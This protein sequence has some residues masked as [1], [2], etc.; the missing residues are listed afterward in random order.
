MLLHRDWGVDEIAVGLGIPEAQVRES[1]TRL[2]DLALLR[3][4][5]EAPKQVRRVSPEV[6]LQL[7]LE[8]R[9]AELLERQ[10]RLAASRAAV[11]ELLADYTAAGSGGV[12]EA[13]ERLDGIDAIQSR[14][15]ELAQRATSVCHSFMPGGA[16]SPQSLAASK[17]LDEQMLRCG[18]EVLTVYLTSMRND[19]ATLGY[20]RWLTE[21]GGKVRTVPTL[22]LRMVLFDREIALVPIDIDDTRRGA[23][24]LTAP[25]VIAALVALFEQIWHSAIPLGDEAERASEELT[26]Q[27][28]EL[29]RLLSQGVTDEV[30]ARQLGISL[31]TER[32]MMAAI[33]RRLGA[34]SRF[35]AGMLAGKRKWTA[36]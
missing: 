25:A 14:L 19:P 33:M 11:S 4:S 34:R 23:V 18:L 22:P 27:E 28:R 12:H 36:S 16:Q 31:R 35:E 29:I 8:R 26:L 3:Q 6:G 9:Q 15:E 32:R 1:L 5:L 10:Q 17:P 30:A 21:L 13:T 20:A 2:A 7:L 24:Q